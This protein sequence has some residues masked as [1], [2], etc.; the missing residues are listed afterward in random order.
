M[1]EFSLVRVSGVS[2]VEFL[3][4]FDSKKKNFFL[5]KESFKA[6]RYHRKMYGFLRAEMVGFSY[7][8]VPS[9]SKTYYCCL[10][11][12]FFLWLLFQVMSALFNTFSQLG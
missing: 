11:I 2:K 5:Q 4:H 3:S 8:V 6:E 10:N 7:K 12:L 1:L 9:S